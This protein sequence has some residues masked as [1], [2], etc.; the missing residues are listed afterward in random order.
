[1]E[2]EQKSV[3]IDKDMSYQ[4]IGG[5]SYLQSR[6]AYLL[7]GFADFDL[8]AAQDELPQQLP[9]A[10]QALATQTRKNN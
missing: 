4:D 7:Q 5:W 3:E 6:A 8:E 9:T 10:P 2:L 1:M